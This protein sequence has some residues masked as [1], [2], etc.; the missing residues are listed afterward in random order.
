MKVE[1]RKLSDIEPYL[2]NS[3]QN[4]AAVDA[5]AKS[6]REF[7]F[8]QPIVVDAEG[9]IIR[10]HTSYKAARKFGPE[11]AGEAVG[12]LA[13]A[14]RFPRRGSAARGTTR[15]NVTHAGA[16]RRPLVPSWRLS[17]KR[18]PTVILRVL[19]IVLPP[20]I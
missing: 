7:G 3:R 20:E 8:R 11:Q 9:V 6:I 13:A 5:V 1:L 2:G 16:P 10:G 14:V 18:F 15:A 17:S 12:R 19:H 4:D